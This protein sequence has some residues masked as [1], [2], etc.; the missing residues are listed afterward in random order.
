MSASGFL[1]VAGGRVEYARWGEGG[2][3]G[4]SPLVLLH[5]GLGCVSTWGGWPA[6]LSRAT[7]REVFAYTR[8]GYGGSSPAD[9]P[10]PL[11]F[12]DREARGVLPR[13]V[14]AAGLRRPVLVGHSDGGTISLLCA[15]HGRTPL[16]GIVTLA[17]HAFNEP[18]C[19]E[20]VRAARDAFRLGALRERLARH[21]GARTEDA[22]RGWCDAWLDPGFEHWSI[23]DE[24]PAITVPLLVVQGRDD[25]YGT[26][27]QPEVIA[28]RASGPSRTVILDDCGHAPH[29]ERPRETIEAISRFLED[30]QTP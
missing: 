9:L 11:D 28:E 14:D 24:L 27:R 17:A 1:A 10:R 23:E 19:I 30:L 12:M 15:A 29:R 6:E 7:G 16:D 13:V 22:F 4:P 2:P 20:G 26:L 8:F 25:T 5:E 3:D 18:W 21:H